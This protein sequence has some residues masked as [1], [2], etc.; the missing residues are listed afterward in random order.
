[1]HQQLKKSK[2]NQNQSAVPIDLLILNL[3]HIQLSHS[4]V[5]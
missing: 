2:T 4:Q 1:M 5:Q 3:E